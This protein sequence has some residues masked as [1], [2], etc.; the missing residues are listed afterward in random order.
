MKNVSGGHRRHPEPFATLRA[1]SVRGRPG[2]RLFEIA[3]ERTPTRFLAT[4]GMARGVRA[5]E[6][7][8]SGSPAY[9]LRLF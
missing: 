3:V 9:R 1:G 5:D 6:R 2:L 4:L 7:F 8:R